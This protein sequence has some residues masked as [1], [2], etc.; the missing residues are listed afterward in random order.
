MKGRHNCSMN[1]EM[2]DNRTAGDG[3]E[4]IQTEPMFTDNGNEESSEF[5]GLP[6]SSLQTET[7]QNEIR[8]K[9]QPSA[10]YPGLAVGSPM[11]SGTIMKFSLI[12]NELKNIQNVWLKRVCNPSK[13]HFFIF[14]SNHIFDNNFLFSYSKDFYCFRQLLR[15]M[16]SNQ[17]LM[18][19]FRS[20]TRNKLFLFKT[21]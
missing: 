15:E 10:G 6:C 3:A 18:T 1:E 14:S 5:A 4:D 9:R 12:S 20:Y 2:S 7:I 19:L 16:K 11:F 21:D 8:K 17:N 13:H